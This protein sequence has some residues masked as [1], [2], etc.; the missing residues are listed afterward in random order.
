MPPEQRANDRPTYYIMKTPAPVTAVSPQGFTHSRSNS[1]SYLNSKP[2]TS[3]LSSS[4]PPSSVAQPQPPKL[5]P[6]P[7]RG[8]VHDART[9]SPNYFGLAVDPTAHAEPR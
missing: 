7:A 1:Q 2:A 9:P 3:P 6:G 5:S 8:A 4:R